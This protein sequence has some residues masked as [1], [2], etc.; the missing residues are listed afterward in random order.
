[1][2][3]E[4]PVVVTA[5]AAVTYR[6]GGDARPALQPID[7]QLDRGDRV[8]V[9]GQSGSGKSTLL[10][11]LAGLL[12]PTQGHVTWPGI[13]HPN[14]RPGSVAMV[15][16][17]PSLVPALTG[18]ANVELPLL[19]AGIPTA[20]ARLRART[21]MDTL[22]L[23]ELAD[24][25]P[26]EMSGGQAQ[27]VAVA[28]AIAGDAA[29]ILAD[30]PTGQLDHASGDQVVT[31]LLVAADHNDAALMIATHDPAVAARMGRQLRLV[32]GHLDAGRVR[33]GSR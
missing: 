11:L 18:L 24:R 20:E 22:G 4:G 31:A 6:T 26:E 19:I 25:L 13:G 33:A 29:A 3:P 2:T 28:R 32:D 10:H 17:A 14:R 21:A 27:R 5:G 12:P 16:Q 1:M 23:A 15:F 30:E 8:A 7:L 9:V